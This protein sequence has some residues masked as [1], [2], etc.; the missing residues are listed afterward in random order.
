MVSLGAV[1]RLYHSYMFSLSLLASQAD[2]VLL[3]VCSFSLAQSPRRITKISG[4]PSCRPSGRRIAPTGPVLGPGQGRSG[5]RNVDFF[6]V[7]FCVR[8]PT[9]S[10]SWLGGLPGQQRVRR[11]RPGLIFFRRPCRPPLSANKKSH[12]R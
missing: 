7:L 12:G 10:L 8:A 3:S 6:F 9:V 4:P 11:G 5:P 2:K 1:Q